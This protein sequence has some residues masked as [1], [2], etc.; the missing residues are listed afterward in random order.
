[1][2]SAS[3]TGCS[4]SAASRAAGVGRLNLWRMNRSHTALTD[5][6]LTHA[7]IQPHHTILD[8]GC[9]GGRTVAKLSA[10][11]TAG[12]TFG[13]D[14]SDASVAASTRANQAAI[15]AGRVEIRCASV[16][17]LPFPA[18]M[19]DLVTAA[20][21]HYYWP[22]LDADLREVLRV[23]K[24]GGALMII[25]EAYKGGKHDAMLQRVGT[26]QERGIMNF[27]LLTVAEHRDLLSAAGYA[28][29]QVFEEYEKGWICA[30]GRRSETEAPALDPREG[31]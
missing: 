21:T 13:V 27:A 3:D 10:L 12:K 15:R 9:G 23:L 25:A 1:M 30:K 29:I 7:P 18:E 5:W 28:D 19:F 31:W 14:Y 6:G 4:S 8:V 20:E 17:Q 2:A 22:A 16:S 11:A 26:L 24:P